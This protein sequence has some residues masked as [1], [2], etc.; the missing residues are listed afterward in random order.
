MCVYLV[1]FDVSILGLAQPLLIVGLF[2][3]VNVK[4]KFI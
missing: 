4:S 2:V 1:K 3:D